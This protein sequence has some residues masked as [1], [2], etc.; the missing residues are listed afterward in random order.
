MYQLWKRFVSG[1][2]VLTQMML[3]MLQFLRFLIG[4][5]LSRCLS[6][7]IMP[8]GF[9]EA[10]EKGPLSGHKI[11]GVRFLLE[12]GANHM[13]DSNEISFIR[14]GEGAL[15]QGF[16]LTWCLHFVMRLR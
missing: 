11:S 16:T 6:L 14:A 7:P 1:F 4:A 12:D 10:C 2:V 8:Q 9:R 5:F 13:V 3:Q 15:K